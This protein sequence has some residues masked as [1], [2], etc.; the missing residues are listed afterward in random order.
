VS[1]IFEATTNLL[2]LAIMAPTA[3]GGIVRVG[4][5]AHLP[6]RTIALGGGF[7]PATGIACY[8]DGNKSRGEGGINADCAPLTLFATIQPRMA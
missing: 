7:R 8:H 3:G 6:H 2:A 5:I 4:A 1:L